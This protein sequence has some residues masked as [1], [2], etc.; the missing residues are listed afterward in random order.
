VHDIVSEERIVS[1]ERA[2]RAALIRGT[3]ALCHVRPGRVGQPLSPES[4]TSPVMRALYRKAAA[5]GTSWHRSR[6]L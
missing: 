2:R 4:H 1:L 3:P 5:Q 6:A